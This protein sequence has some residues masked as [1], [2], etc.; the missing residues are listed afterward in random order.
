MTPVIWLTA[1]G[2][3]Q[4]ALKSVVCTAFINDAKLSKTHEKN[5][6]F[7]KSCIVKGTISSEDKNE[8]N[9]KIK[10]NFWVPICQWSGS[11][12]KR[13]LLANIGHFLRIRKN[14]S[15]GRTKSSE[16]RADNQEIPTLGSRT[17]PN[18]HTL[19]VSEYLTESHK[20]YGAMTTMYFIF[21]FFNYL[22]TTITTQSLPWLLFLLLY[23]NFLVN[24]FL[25]KYLLYMQM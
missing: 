3:K 23:N 24:L 5:L 15:V 14:N 10:R 13:L 4:H 8:N 25:F 18:P 19:H 1:Q 12:L 16:S 2:E 17:G 9:I 20:C 6:S 7:F 21:P 22:W 11:S